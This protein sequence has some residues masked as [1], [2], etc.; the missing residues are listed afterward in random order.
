ML[1]QYL[2]ARLA[3][4]KEQEYSA[5]ARHAEFVLENRLHLADIRV[6]DGDQFGSFFRRVKP[7]LWRRSVS[8]LLGRHQQDEPAAGQGFSAQMNAEHCRHAGTGR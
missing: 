5:N 3:E 2:W 7:T 1:N 8:A 4:N 6:G